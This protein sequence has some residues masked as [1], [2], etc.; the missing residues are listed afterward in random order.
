MKLDGLVTVVAT[1]REACGLCSS[2]ANGQVNVVME[3]NKGMTHSC[4]YV[5]GVETWLNR[6][7]GYKCMCMKWRIKY[8]SNFCNV[9]FN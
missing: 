6:V 1:V 5:F 9:L 4:V 2:N 7:Q 8:K 3:T